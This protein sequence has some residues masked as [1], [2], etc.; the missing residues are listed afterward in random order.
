MNEPLTIECCGESLVLTGERALYRPSRSLLML[1]DLHLG[2]DDIFRRSGVAVPLGSARADLQRIS[3]LAERFQA[4]RVVVLGD[5]LH[6]QMR[7]LDA[8]L[9]ELAQWQ[10]QNRL[11]LDVVVGNHDRFRG[12]QLLST[13]ARWIENEEID[14]PFVYRHQ[15]DSSDSGYVIC[16]HLH[17]SIRLESR[18]RDRIRVP[19]FWFRSAYAVLPAFGSFTGGA[20]VERQ[21]G[22][23]M[24]AVVEG[25][26]FALPDLNER[27]GNPF[28]D[29]ASSSLRRKR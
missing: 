27:S 29:S 28:A 23:R 19:A 11:L 20:N 7:A 4:R 26:V 1:A 16:G 10:Q 12:Q 3:H 5:F 17:P 18:A 9:N 25:S 14:P 21:S 13:V 24:Y 2:K 8:F 22:D 15:P 6:G